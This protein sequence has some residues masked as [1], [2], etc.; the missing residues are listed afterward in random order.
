[1]RQYKTLI[2]FNESAKSIPDHVLRDRHK[3]NDY[4]TCIQQNGES[5]DFVPLTPLQLYNGD[6]VRWDSTPYI[7]HAH[8]IIKDSG[9]PIFLGAR[10]P[11]KSQLKPCRWR[12][13]LKQYWGKQ[14]PD[15][16]QFGFPLDFDRRQLLC[17]TDKNHTSALE[18]QQHVAHYISEEL[19]YGALYGPPIQIPFA[20]HMSPL[21]VRDKH[22]LHYVFHPLTSS[23]KLYVN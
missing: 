10:I 8:H 11:V 20:A 4:R 22:T 12:Y 5:F 1:M 13:H 14:L 2:D 3:H 15:L 16:I 9:L 6:S 21:M 23:H 17:S 19:S 18:N 7:I